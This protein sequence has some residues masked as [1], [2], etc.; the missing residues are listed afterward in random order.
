[1]DLFSILFFVVGV[2]LTILT[3]IYAHAMYLY[4][5]GDLAQQK[6]R[7]EESVR[8]FTKAATGINP[9]GRGMAWAALGRVYLKMGRPDDALEPLRQALTKT[10]MPAAILAAYQLFADTALHPDLK[11][12]A[13]TV[14]AEGEMLMEKTRMPGPMKAM[15][16]SQ[17][18][19][20]WMRL[21]DAERAGS[22]I[23]AALAQDAINPSALYLQGWTRLQQGDLDGAE[24]SFKKLLGVRQKDQ[25]PLGL[26]GLG[27]VAFY[28]GDLPRAD[29][30]YVKAVGEG[31]NLL[32][33]FA[34]AR[35]AL[36]RTHTGQGE[37]D[38][39][40]RK[41]EGVLN[42][43]FTRGI[44]GR[45]S[46]ARWVV[47]MARAWRDQDVDE[48]RAAVELAPEPER[49]EALRLAA[50]VTGNGDTGGWKLTPPAKP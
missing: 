5:R 40:I 1:M 31:S 37:V 13:R 23:E 34:R 21:G 50:V 20:A 15:L 36:V 16:C 29:E 2:P 17:F 10:K 11:G 43:L 26:Y 47:A 32:E 12:D 3:G 44:V 46:G 9:I 45:N 41:A 33:P 8:R 4:A 30:L 18:A 42:E 25:R 28:R 48:A 14:L 19:H 35:L 22:M 7:Y 24:E 6:G 39:N 38:E 27:T 49:A